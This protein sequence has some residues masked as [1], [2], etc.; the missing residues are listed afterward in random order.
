LYFFS[1]YTTNKHALIY[2]AKNSTYDR[3]KLNIIKKN[4]CPVEALQILSKDDDV[5]IRFNVLL[6]D[7]V[8]KEIVESMLNDE[9]IRISNTAKQI[10]EDKFKNSSIKESLIKQYIRLMMS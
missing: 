1:R 7:N 5:S 4:I 3:I 8:T 10:L 6:S 9:N 2:L